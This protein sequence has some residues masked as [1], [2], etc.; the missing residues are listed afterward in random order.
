MSETPETLENICKH[1]D[2]LL[3]HPVK[4]FETKIENV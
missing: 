3:Q 4:T 2:L 1:P